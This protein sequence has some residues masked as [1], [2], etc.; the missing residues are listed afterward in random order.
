MG[1]LFAR[2]L[3][4]GLFFGLANDSVLS[5]P[6]HV[7]KDDTI[8]LLTKSPGYHQ[9]RTLTVAGTGLGF[10]SGVMIGL[11]SLWYQDYERTSFHFYNDQS[12][13]LQ[14]D[15]AG[16]LYS[17]YLFGHL[18]LNTLQWAGVKDEKAIWYGGLYG[19]FF[20]TT[21][22]ILDG[23]SAKWGAS[24]TDFAAN[25]AGSALLIG[26]EILWNEQRIQPKFSW[27][28]KT[29][30][31]GVKPRARELF[32]SSLQEQLIKDY[33]AQTLWLSF[34]MNDFMPESNI[35]PWLNIAAGYSGAQMLDAEQATYEVTDNKTIE[36]YRQY[37]IAPDLDWSKIETDSQF[38]N[39]LF[40]MANYLKFPTPALEYNSKG[41]VKFHPVYY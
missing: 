21:V 38:L 41:Q 18:G 15:K 13:W 37:F 11:N 19:S 32:G 23:F 36:R 24:P 26:Q 35:P 33:N 12:G 14:V 7:Y 2:I 8:G 22:E 16:H 34:N 39:L 17:A 9:S 10:Y 31:E 6:L 5:Q 3:L 29:Y 27:F 1:G 40:D 4:I 25:T 30:Q 20:L 28:P